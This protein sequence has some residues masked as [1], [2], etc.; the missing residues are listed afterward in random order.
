MNSTLRFEYTA[1][2]V[3]CIVTQPDSLC[4]S[5]KLREDAKGQDLLDAVRKIFQH[6][7]NGGQSPTR[8]NY[9]VHL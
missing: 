9:Y 2:K 1:G 3:W 6:L 8:P 5:I 4:I 7:Y